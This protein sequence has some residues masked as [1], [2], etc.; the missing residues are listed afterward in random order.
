MNDSAEPLKQASR[1]G[2]IW[3]ILTIILGILA[4]GS[5]LVSGLAVALLVGM[6]LLAAGISMTLFAFQAPSL[7]RG[8]LKFLFG[9]LTIVVGITMLAQPG[10]A[11]VDL[12]LLLGFYF[13]ADGVVAMI[14]AFNV[15]PQPG[16]GWMTFNG[17][18]TIALG[19][20]ILKGWPVSG[21]WAIGI[22]V[23][24][25]LLFAGMTMLTLGTAA[26]QVA[27]TMRG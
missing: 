21:V 1:M 14:V 15:K 18:V 10:I 6:A 13:I 4:I 16:W 8:V 22:L 17:I 23:G 7:G 26:N 9:A 27:K 12:T 2:I 25:R 11:L 5:P 20:M 19:W 3:G 24:I